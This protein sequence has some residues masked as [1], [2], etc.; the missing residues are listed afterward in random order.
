M[1]YEKHHFGENN[2]ISIYH[3]IDLVFDQHYHRSFELILVEEG[4]I[5]LNVG[6][7][8]YL[9]TKR[10]S[11]LISPH[12]HHDIKS[13]PHSVLIIFIFSPE[14]VEDFY[15]QSKNHVFSHPILKIPTQLLNASKEILLTPSSTYKKKALLYN[16]IDRYLNNSNLVPK[17]NINDTVIED[18]RAYI[19]DNFTTPI[20][21]KN[22]STE[23]GYSY[24]YLS[25]LI[26]KELNISFNELLNSYRINRANDLL[27]N[28]NLT[29][30]EIAYLSGFQNLRS[31]NRNFKLIQ[32]ISPTEY[33]QL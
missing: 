10:H 33:K 28:T 11:F 19:E 7:S 13:L 4:Q 14:L 18:V 23:L 6:D 5:E 1:T 21:L 16:Y 15:Q 29:I 26:N 31:F 32:S 3:P 27:K 17:N 20:T 9:V 22:L 2:S 30:T 24:N 12:Q 8:T 25:G